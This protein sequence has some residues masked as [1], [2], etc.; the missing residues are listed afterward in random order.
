MDETEWGIPIAVFP[1]GE[2]L[3]RV[4]DP[5]KTPIVGVH[6]LE[7]VHGWPRDLR[8]GRFTLEP[9][10]ARLQETPASFDLFLLTNAEGQV[11]LSFLL[12]VYEAGPDIHIAELRT[13]FSLDPRRTKLREKVL[14]VVSDLLGADPLN[15]RELSV[16]PQADLFIPVA[17]SPRTLSDA[18]THDDI[19]VAWQNDYLRRFNMGD[20]VTKKPGMDSLIEAVESL[21]GVLQRRN[22]I[23]FAERY[24]DDVEEDGRLEWRLYFGGPRILSL[25]MTFEDDA[26]LLDDDGNVKQRGWIYWDL[27]TSDL[28]AYLANEKPSPLA[29]LIDGQMLIPDTTAESV[30]DAIIPDAELVIPPNRLESYILLGHPTRLAW[31]GLVE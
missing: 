30:L 23:Q 14:W 18:K 19:T 26:E 4:I 5:N 29:A 10:H 25:S 8:T 9:D 7:Q 16:T 11:G 12:K 21:F 2:I 17:T 1:D 15:P 13:P 22:V 31:K 20:Q 24:D 6:V 3:H 27:A 28:H